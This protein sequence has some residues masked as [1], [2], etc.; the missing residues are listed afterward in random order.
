MIVLGA[1]AWLILEAFDFLVT[2]QAAWHLGRI[3]PALRR[4][5]LQVLDENPERFERKIRQSGPSG[6]KVSFR[7]R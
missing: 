3:W 2:T 4:A 6:A 5:T 1:V 7:R